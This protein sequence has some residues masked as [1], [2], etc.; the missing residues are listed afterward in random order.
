MSAI[1]RA[2]RVPNELDSVQLHGP[3][4]GIGGPG[5]TAVLH[6]RAR[7]PVASNESS[8]VRYFSPRFFSSHFITGCMRHEEAWM[9][10]IYG[11]K[12]R[13]G[14]EAI[15]A[16]SLLFGQHFHFALPSK[17]TCCELSMLE[18]VAAC[19]DND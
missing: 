2:L 1:C 9:A 8:R 12:L 11:K 14:D 19:C 6:R 4:V 15:E 13:L 3:S 18:Q 5:S 7:A 10:Q 17:L 16:C